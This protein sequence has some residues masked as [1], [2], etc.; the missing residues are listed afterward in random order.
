[1]NLKLYFCTIFIT[2][3][4]SNVGKVLRFLFLCGCVLAAACTPREQHTAETCV[5]DTLSVD[6]VQADTLLLFEQDE[7]EDFRRDSLYVE[8]FDDFLY[9]FGHDSLFRR[10]RVRFPFLHISSTGDSVEV[11]SRDWG[12]D[13]AFLQQDFYTVFYNTQSQIEET[14]ALSNDTVVVERIDLDSLMLTSYRFIRKKGSWRLH[15]QQDFYVQGSQLADFLVFYRQFSTD[16]I[17]QQTSIAQPL[18]FCM[19]DPDDEMEVIE[20]TIDATQWFSFCPEVPLG[21]ISN[22][23][24]GQT[25]DM[26]Q[27][28]VMQKCAQGSGFMEIFNFEKTDGL[29]RLTSY[30][31]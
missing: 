11:S 5:Q 26:P 21:I 15:Q 4:M 18:H 3:Q 20:G 9:S 31:N 30:E 17:F 12:G 23:R 7:E 16:S 14:K 2:Y 24:Y 13:F 19:E 29:W 10:R 22:I 8:Y 28:I 27:R 6:T 25:Y 1:M